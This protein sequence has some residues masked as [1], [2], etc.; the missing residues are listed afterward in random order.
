MIKE[1]GVAAGCASSK[2][3]A[4]KLFIL[5]RFIRKS[6]HVKVRGRGKNDREKSFCGCRKFTDSKY[7]LV[8]DIPKLSAIGLRR[9]KECKGLNHGKIRKN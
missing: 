4:R 9:I 8:S 5:Q 7:T 1:I 2:H 3:Q 6:V